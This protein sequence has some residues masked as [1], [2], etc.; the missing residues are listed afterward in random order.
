MGVQFEYTM[1]GTPQQNIEICYSFK[2][3]MCNAQWWEI[4]FFLRNGLW[5]EAASTATLLKNDLIIPTR[6][7]SPFQHFLGCKTETS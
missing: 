1:S 2:Q 5:A 6:D 7:S 3:D 4:F